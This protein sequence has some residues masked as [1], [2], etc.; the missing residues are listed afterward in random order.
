MVAEN[1][2]WHL[3]I[4]IVDIVPRGTHIWGQ[5]RHLFEAQNKECH[6]AAIAVIAEPF[7]VLLGSI[8]NCK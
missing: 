4:I 8:P 1:K 7:R 5:V 2:E 6:M 3:V